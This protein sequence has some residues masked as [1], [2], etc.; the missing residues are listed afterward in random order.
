[1]RTREHQVHV[2][3]NGTAVTVFV[4]GRDAVLWHGDIELG[5]TSSIF[6]NSFPNPCSSL[7]LSWRSNLK[8]RIGFRAAEIPFPDVLMA[9]I[10]TLL[11]VRTCVLTGLISSNPVTRHHGSRIRCSLFCSSSESAKK[12]SPMV[13]LDP[14]PDFPHTWL[15]KLTGLSS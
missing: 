4:L 6:S 12:D 2:L 9:D 13:S 10:R 1:L 5:F 14:Y 7:H 11:E 15:A 8:Q 3:I